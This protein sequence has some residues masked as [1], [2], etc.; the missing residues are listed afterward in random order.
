MFLLIGVTFFLVERGVDE[1]TFEAGLTE[2][3]RRHA[4]EEVEAD[5]KAS[6]SK[7]EDDVDQKSF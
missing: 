3:R 6:E 1:A 5:A 4:H 7:V 2:W